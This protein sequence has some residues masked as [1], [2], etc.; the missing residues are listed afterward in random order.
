MTDAF[1]EDNSQLD[2]AVDAEIAQCVDLTN[3]RSFFLF[4]G[5]GSGKTRSLITALNHVRAASGDMLRRR[6]SKIGVITYT[7]AACDEIIR[8]A[9]FDPLIHVST[10]HSFAWSLIDGFDRDIRIWVERHLVASIAEL[11][12]EEQKGRP[13]TKASATRLASI[14]SKER[15]LADL[16]TIRRFIY[17]PTGDNRTRDS[18]NH[19][20]VLGIT[21]AFLND[22][23]TLRKVVASRFPYIFVDECQD[24]N[25]ALVDALFALE[26]AHRGAFGLGLLGDTM[27][28]IYADGKPNIEASLPPEWAR[29]AKKLNHRCPKRVVN[30]INRIRSSADHQVQIPRTD[31]PDGLVRVFCLPADTGDKPRSEASA[32]RR[33]AEFTGDPSWTEPERRKTLI[34]EHHMAATRMGFAGVFGA[35][36]IDDFR[37]GLLDGTLPAMTIFSHVMLP[38]ARAHQARD[39]FALAKIVRENS[40]LLSKDALRNA[41]Q[42][43]DQ[44]GRARAAAE[45]LGH[46]LEK[47]DPTLH[48]LAETVHETALFELPDIVGATLAKAKPAKAGAKQKAED[49]KADPVPERVAAIEAFLK[50]RF[51]EIAPYAAYV[52]GTAP[53]DTHQGVKGLEFPR[54]MVVIDDTEARGFMFKYDKLFTDANTPAARGDD[55]ESTADRTRRLFY[56]TCS[57]AEKSL[58]IV[59]YAADPKALAERLGATGWFE[60]EEICL[61]L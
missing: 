31:S 14:A 51:S 41:P 37:T 54:V 28:R 34:L 24:T 22:K 35:L 39:K 53:F 25:K 50:C 18:L 60:K 48:E 19:A 56:V 57:R 47:G 27:Q 3:P 26:Q 10:I 7:N 61:T 45:A 29:P 38:F 58:A 33:M 16:P 8:R 20:E 9:E 11:R 12:A 17:S 5:A 6:G 23:P 36:L 2:A 4:A 43:K 13:G 55:K 1:I 46:I 52:S 32:A 30:L 42:Q 40:P 21:A 44:L 59:A 15:R 49:E